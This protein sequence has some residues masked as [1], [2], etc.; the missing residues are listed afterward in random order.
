MCVHCELGVAR[1]PENILRSIVHEV[2]NGRVVADL[3]KEVGATIW[4][5]CLVRLANYGVER[6]VPVM[7]WLQIGDTGGNDHFH[8]LD[9]VLR[10]GSEGVVVGAD[11]AHGR[12]RL[13]DAVVVHRFDWQGHSREIELAFHDLRADLGDE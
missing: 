12:H 7:R 3:L 13:Q 5:L 10:E 1:K 4:A 9:G 2:S 8:A 11:V 6:L